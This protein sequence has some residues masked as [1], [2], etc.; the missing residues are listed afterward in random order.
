MDTLPANINKLNNL[1]HFDL[2]NNRLSEINQI[3][4]MPNLRILNISGNQKLTELPFEL[5]TCDSLV[6]LIFDQDV[7]QHPPRHISAQ[8]TVEVIKYLL[9]SERAET[10]RIGTVSSTKELDSASWIGERATSTFNH[11]KQHVITDHK[12]QYSVNLRS[13]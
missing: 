4:C 13:E 8:S 10:S 9:S 5:S 7:V 11:K 1:Q 3:N 2:S 12:Q 6:E